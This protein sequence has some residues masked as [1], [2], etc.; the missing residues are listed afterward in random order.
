M[1][2][3]LMDIVKSYALKFCVPRLEPAI[4][5]VIRKSLKIV[6]L[7]KMSYIN[8]FGLYMNKINITSSAQFNSLGLD[9]TFLSSSPLKR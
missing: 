1:T 3:S 6:I 4:H 7:R 5:Y 9:C 8:V 2:F